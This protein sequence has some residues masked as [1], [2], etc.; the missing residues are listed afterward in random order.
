MLV[1]KSML[2][3]YNN[4]DSGIKYTNQTCKVNGDQDMRIIG[5]QLNH[6]RNVGHGELSFDRLPSG[7]SMTGIY[8]QNGSGKTAVIDAIAILD[9]LISGDRLPEYSNDIIDVETGTATITATMS[10]DETIIEYT[11]TLTTGDT[12]SGN[13]ALVSEE[14]IR[15]GNAPDRLGRIILRHTATDTGFTWHPSYLRRSINALTD[16]DTD[17]RRAEEYAYATNRSFLFS[18]IH[19]ARGRETQTRTVTH[20]CDTLKAN[21]NVAERTRHYVEDTASRFTRHLDRLI[22]SARN[23]VY[24]SKTKRG[25]LAVFWYMP[26]ESSRTGRS[27]L[28]NLTATTP[29]PRA[30][31][32]AI[33]SAIDIYNMVL[34]TIIPGLHVDAVISP[35][36]A[37]E[38]GEE[39]VN[40]QL[41]SERDGRRIP[42]RC[43]SEGVIRLTGMLSYFIH[44][45]N[46]PDALVAIDEIDTGVYE[47]LLGDLLKQMAEGMKGQLVFTAHNLRALETIPPSC[48]RVTTTNPT[49]RYATFHV[50]PSNNNRR[51]YLADA[52]LGSE[53]DNLYDP[54]LPHMFGA[55]LYCAAHPDDD[56]QDADGED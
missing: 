50:K 47:L 40:L 41:M 43:E 9:H 15:V 4:H 22:D 32:N 21:N 12:E 26:V 17:M 53:G 30:D 19:D 13:R 28:I 33:R 49:R 35:A 5:L 24:V 20:M 16:L 44:A 27:R 39:R 51:K 23:A 6:V 42:F 10:F 8:G 55:A 56:T 38:E 11:V 2:Q 25:A 14:A 34:P 29:V 52:L 48:V 3:R 7:G 54:P 1:V 45:F 37:S 36:P 31:A 46:D 18:T